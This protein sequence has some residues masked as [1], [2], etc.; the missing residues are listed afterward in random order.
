MALAC[1]LLIVLCVRKKKRRCLV[2]RCV[3]ACV[4]CVSS[5]ACAF[6]AQVRMRA[7]QDREGCKHGIGSP[8][9]GFADA[10]GLL[11]DFVME[12]GVQE[13]GMGRGK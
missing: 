9:V 12:Y 7:M 2:H 8:C 4:M 1:C 5:V 10:A 3:Y 11:C 13:R 6:N